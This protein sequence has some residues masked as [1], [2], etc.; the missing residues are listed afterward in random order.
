MVIVAVG[1]MVGMECDVVAEEEKKLK[2]VKWIGIFCLIIYI[3]L[4]SEVTC[5]FFLSNPN[6][7]S[8]PPAISNLRAI[9]ASEVAY[10][11]TNGHYAGSF[12]EL[13]SATPPYL[14]GNWDH[15]KS[16]YLFTVKG[17]GDKFTVHAAPAPPGLDGTIW[18]FG[19][20]TGVI[21]RSEDGSANAQSPVLYE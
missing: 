8:E 1:K 4:L 10:A 11:A 21:R 6:P 3:F 13:T 9:V 12:E 18:Y 17:E 7:A 20:E 19:D 15:P 16:G 2:P 14:E 5:P